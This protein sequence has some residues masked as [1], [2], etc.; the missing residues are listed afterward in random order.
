[1]LNL[2]SQMGGVATGFRAFQIETKLFTANSIMVKQ[3]LEQKMKTGDLDKDAQIHKYAYNISPNTLKNLTAPTIS[4][5]IQHF[6]YQIRELSI[7]NK[8]GLL[9]LDPILSEE[10][11]LRVHKRSLYEV[12]IAAKAAH[13]TQLVLFFTYNPL[14]DQ[15]L[16]ILTD[17][18]Y[19]I[20]LYE[21]SS[22]GELNLAPYLYCLVARL[23]DDILLEDHIQIEWDHLLVQPLLQPSLKLPVTTPNIT[24][25]RLVLWDIPPCLVEQMLR[26]ALPPPK[27]ETKNKITFIRTLVERTDKPCWDYDQLSH[28]DIFNIQSQPIKNPLLAAQKLGW[29]QQYLPGLVY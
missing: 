29:A 8:K 16:D 13:S 24:L 28:L 26:V 3:L 11:K 22:Q 25:Q 20:H 23:R 4:A 17:R 2:F 14:W 27:T 10:D 7:P 1:M 6:K 12:I 21:F 18:D 15:S 5:L 9:D 19:Q